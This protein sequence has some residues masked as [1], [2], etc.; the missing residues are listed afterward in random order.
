MV[1]I[2]FV[3]YR[4]VVPVEN[5]FCLMDE[6]GGRLQLFYMAV[7]TTDVPRQIVK[8][9]VVLAFLDIDLVSVFLCRGIPIERLEG[10][11]QFLHELQE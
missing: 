9:L 11:A 4:P 1:F 8:V 2:G 5:L 7:V 10:L 3:V 6:P